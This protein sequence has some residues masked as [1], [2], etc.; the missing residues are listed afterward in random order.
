MWPCVV[1]TA[2]ESGGFILH[3]SMFGSVHSLCRSHLWNL[4]HSRESTSQHIGQRLIHFFEYVAF[5]TLLM[6]WRLRNL[7]IDIAGALCQAIFLGSLYGLTDE[8]HQYFVPYR[9]A[10]PVGWV[11][12]TLGSVLGAFAVSVLFVVFSKRSGPV[13]DM[14]D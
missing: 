1:Y 14:K 12:D 8:L 3:E 7:A 4:F 10:G 11:A 5:G 2:S 13:K 6:W 9:C